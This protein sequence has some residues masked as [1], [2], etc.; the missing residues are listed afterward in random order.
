[1]RSLATL[2]TQT[3][4]TYAEKQGHAQKQDNSSRTDLNTLWIRRALAFSGNLS[5]RTASVVIQKK[6][7]TGARRLVRIMTPACGA[8][9]PGFKSQRARHKNFQSKNKDLLIGLRESLS[10]LIGP[11]SSAGIHIR[12]RQAQPVE[13]TDNP[14]DRLPCSVVIGT[15]V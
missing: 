8:G 3:E 5:S 14:S 12:L 15:L 4:A 13:R 2:T 7:W 9:G 6:A 10:A 1:M 11:K